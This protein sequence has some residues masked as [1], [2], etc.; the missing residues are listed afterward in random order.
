[1]PVLATVLGI[2]SDLLNVGLSASGQ[3]K[4]FAWLL[5]PSAKRFGLRLSR[6]GSVGRTTL[7][8]LLG[9]T[10]YRF[11]RRFRQNQCSMLRGDTVCPMLASQRSARS[12]TFRG[13][14]SV[15]GPKGIWQT[16][17]ETAPAS[18]IVYVSSQPPRAWIGDVSTVWLYVIERS[19]ARASQ[20]HDAENVPL[21]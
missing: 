2:V 21:S 13:Q 11:M 14:D 12:L 17:T 19:A 15:T 20:V 4:N 7:R 8:D 1:M 16:D 6:G 3:K 18:G 5:S 10:A 9:T